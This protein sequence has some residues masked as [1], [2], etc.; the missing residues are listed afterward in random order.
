MELTVYPAPIF[1][2][3]LCLPQVFVVSKAKSLSRYF[4]PKN[5]INT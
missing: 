3:F 4:D 5:Y 1:I 2:N